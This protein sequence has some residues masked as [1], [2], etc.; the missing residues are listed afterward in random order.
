MVKDRRHHHRIRDCQATEKREIKNNKPDK[1]EL[2]IIV[3]I[4][5]YSL[6]P[7]QLR[8]IF[9][10]YI[11]AYD[12]KPDKEKVYPQPYILERNSNTNKSIRELAQVYLFNSTW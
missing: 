2:I 6:F 7:I 3:S 8:C 12:S 5:L 11:R 9:Y 1:L 10:Y 4:R